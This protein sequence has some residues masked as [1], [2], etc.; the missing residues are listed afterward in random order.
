M[1]R[2]SLFF[3]LLFFAIPLPSAQAASYVVKNLELNGG[4]SSFV[5]DLTVSSSGSDLYVRTFVT[6]LPG[7]DRRHKVT[8]SGLPSNVSSVSYSISSSDCSSISNV[9][10]T[11]GGFSYEFP[12]NC[13]GVLVARYL[14]AGISDGT[15]T[16]SAVVTDC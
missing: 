14:T 5:R 1:K 2:S 12:G 13:D 8:L 16:F 4:G 9:S 6:P 3:L 10:L 7:S 15:H 11:S